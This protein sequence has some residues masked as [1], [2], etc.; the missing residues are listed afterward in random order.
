MNPTFVLVFGFVS[1]AL[2]TL[3]LLGIRPVVVP[4]TIRT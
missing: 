4:A 1:A 3:V 2:F